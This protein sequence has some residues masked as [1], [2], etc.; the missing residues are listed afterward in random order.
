[1]SEVVLADTG[2]LVAILNQS[3]QHHKQSIEA[4]KTLRLPLLTC[5]PVLTEAAYLLRQYPDAVAK[6]LEGLQSGFLELL[7]LDESDASAIR[8]ILST[9]RDQGY[10]LA[11]ASLMHLAEREDI[12]TVFTLDRRDFDVY[13]PQAFAALR[14]LPE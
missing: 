1:M 8:G 4:L 2:P 10:Q 9:Y 7:P 14:L 11:D 6:L 12:A 3:D 13:R 5:W